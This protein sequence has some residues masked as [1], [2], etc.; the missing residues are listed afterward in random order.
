MQR[1]AGC[2]TDTG[3]ST[4]DFRRSIYPSHSSIAPT[5]T[6]SLFAGE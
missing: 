4:C 3:R 1:I 5:G 2:V 6:I